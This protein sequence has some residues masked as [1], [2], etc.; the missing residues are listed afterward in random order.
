MHKTEHLQIAQ[1]DPQPKFAKELF[2][3][4]DEPTNNDNFANVKFE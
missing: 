3:F 4:A 2:F 1:D